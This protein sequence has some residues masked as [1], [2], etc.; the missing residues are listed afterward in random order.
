MLTFER[1][2][3]S[4][5][6]CC[7][8][9]SVHDAR[10]R[11]R[12]LLAYA[13]LDTS[14]SLSQVSRRETPCCRLWP[15][16]PRVTGTQWPTSMFARSC[17]ADLWVL[18]GCQE[19]IPQAHNTPDRPVPDRALCIGRY[20]PVVTDP[21]TATDRVRPAT[22]PLRAEF[23]ICHGHSFIMLGSGSCQCVR[24]VP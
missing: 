5:E 3:V 24:E 12:N 17:K 11:F 4:L 13:P 22:P 1:Q 18:I 20:P 6:D 19:F 15:S 7:H 10:L 14:G 21:D 2:A 23:V 8:P 9:L 16:I